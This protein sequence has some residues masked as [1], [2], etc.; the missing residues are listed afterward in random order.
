M[1]KTIEHIKV[2]WPLYLVLIGFA[3]TI[4]GYSYRFLATEAKAD[5]AVDGLATVNEIVAAHT[6]K[7]ATQETDITN[8]ATGIQR[9]EGKVDQL[10]DYLIKKK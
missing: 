6:T 2:W 1:K 3:G 8:V 9:V 5:V 4:F 10:V 7:I